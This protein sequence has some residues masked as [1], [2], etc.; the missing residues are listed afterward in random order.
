[1]EANEQDIE[2][3][4]RYLAGELQGDE[5]KAVE[6][7]I[8]SDPDFAEAV[9]VQRD[10]AEAIKA[11]GRAD[12]KQRLKG[13]EAAVIASGEINDY[14]PDQGNMGGKGSTPGSSTFWTIGLLLAGFLGI[15]VYQEFERRD[16]KKAIETEQKDSVQVQDTVKVEKKVPVK[17]PVQPKQET[18]IRYDTVYTK[19]KISASGEVLEKSSTVKKGKEVKSSETQTESDKINLPNQESNNDPIPEEQKPN[20]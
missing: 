18:I 20:E 10:L 16:F 1:M 12:L 4:E 7:R 13:I 2:L 6:D 5:L 17:K 9:E 11:S 3:I 15:L 19:R 8:G 14:R